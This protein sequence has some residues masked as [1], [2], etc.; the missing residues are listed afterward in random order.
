[1]VPIFVDENGKLHYNESTAYT[2]SARDKSNILIATKN[3]EAIK[4]AEGSLGKEP[5]PKAHGSHL[6]KH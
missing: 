6:I 3:P 1:M 4:S 5:K 2:T